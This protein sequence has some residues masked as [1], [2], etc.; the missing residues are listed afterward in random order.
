[1]PYVNIRVTDEGVAREQVECSTWML[2][3]VLDKNPTITE[4]V[5]DEVPTENWGAGGELVDACRSRERVT[6]A[7]RRAWR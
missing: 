7:D 5:M 6:Q 2:S 4:V 1:M 3:E